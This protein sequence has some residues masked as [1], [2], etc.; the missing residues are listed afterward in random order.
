MKLWI[1]EQ[2]G[3]NIGYDQCYR[4]VIRAK[5]ENRARQMAKLNAQFE[6]PDI[7]ISATKTSCTHLTSNGNEELIISDINWG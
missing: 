5:T 4:M 2:F 6:Q 7:W 3:P 1:L